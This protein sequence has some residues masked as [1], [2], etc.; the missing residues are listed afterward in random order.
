MTSTDTSSSALPA[1]FGEAWVA[2]MRTALTAGAAAL[3]DL[4]RRAGDGD[5][6]TNIRTAMKLVEKNLDEDS[7]SGY[8]ATLTSFYRAW[9][10]VGG[11][12]GPL[13]GMLFRDLSK[14]G[15]GSGAPTITEFAE[16]L[17]NGL[18]TVQRYGEA[19]VGDKTMVDALAPAAEALTSAA[20][21]G[22]DPVAAL[23]AAVDA[24]RGGADATAETIAR[25][26]RASYVGDAAKG[27]MDPG[28]AAV[29]LILAAAR[30][31]AGGEE[32]VE[33]DWIG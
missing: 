11:T 1:D 3:G 18:A 4:D 23:G 12:S 19:E 21:S 2:Q 22:D 9:L 31:A 33:T 32:S 27:V 14:A 25:R 10:G 8:S 17:A 7:P 13:F 16:A 5:F 29:V 28:A 20:Q 6:G 30:S 24:A 26:G 15:E